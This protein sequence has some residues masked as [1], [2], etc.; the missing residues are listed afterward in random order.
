MNLVADA[1]IFSQW[2]DPTRRLPRPVRAV[3]HLP[4]GSQQF[5]FLNPEPHSCYLTKL[6]AAIFRTR[7]QEEV[8]HPC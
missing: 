5:V 1:L 3:L 7:Q 4:L 6:D 8:R 2:K